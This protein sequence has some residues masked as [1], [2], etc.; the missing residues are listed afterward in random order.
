MGKILGGRVVQ[1]HTIAAITK[2][3]LE[4]V[5]SKWNLGISK[6]EYL[7]SPTGDH[8]ILQLDFLDGNKKIYDPT[9]GFILE[10]SKKKYQ[11]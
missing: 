7:G 1:C 10:K 5:N 9:H 11:V 2:L 3:I 8:T 4:E 6:I